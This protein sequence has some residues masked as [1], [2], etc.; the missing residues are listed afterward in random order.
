MKSGWKIKVILL[1]AK[2]RE[3]FYEQFGFVKRPNEREGCG[4]NLVIVK[5]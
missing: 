3:S 1:A 4:M 5:E 2:G